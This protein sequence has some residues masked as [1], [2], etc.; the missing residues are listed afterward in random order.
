MLC[1]GLCQVDLRQQEQTC[2]FGSQWSGDT[3][4]GQLQ[5]N[6]DGSDDISEFLEGYRRKQQSKQVELRELAQKEGRPYSAPV[7]SPSC[8][9]IRNRSTC[10]LALQK[11]QSGK[12]AG[13]S[14][15]S[16]II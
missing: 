15:A 8:S 3:S 4:H 13:T 5:D 11:Q 12:Y 9:S 16:D 7:A 14:N 10:D 6:E 2:L 1:H